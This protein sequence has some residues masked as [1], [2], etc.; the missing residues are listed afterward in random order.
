MEINKVKQGFCSDRKIKNS[1]PRKKEK[2]IDKYLTTSRQLPENSEAMAKNWLN[3]Q[4]RGAH[5]QKYSNNL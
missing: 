5:N 3:E 2:L 4:P 1:F